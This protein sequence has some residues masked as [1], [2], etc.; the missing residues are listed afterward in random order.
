MELQGLYMRLAVNGASLGLLVA[1]FVLLAATRS[2]PLAPIAPAR[3]A[4]ASTPAIR[5][6]DVADVADVCVRACA[7][8]PS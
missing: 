8:L 4:R 5:L 3:V 2:A 6:T 7:S 1:F